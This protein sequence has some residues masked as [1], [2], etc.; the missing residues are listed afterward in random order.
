[1][2]INKYCSELE[3]I[4]EMLRVS[5][6]QG[7]VVLNQYLSKYSEIGSQVNNHK[8]YYLFFH[9]AKFEIFLCG[10][11]GSHERLNSICI[12]SYVLVKKAFKVFSKKFRLNVRHI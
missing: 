5:A 10:F 1:M 4:S 9:D 7:G 12:F 2:Q 3:N 6:F 8:K 11:Q